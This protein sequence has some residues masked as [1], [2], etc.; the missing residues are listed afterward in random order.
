ME[1]HEG[2][3]RGTALLLEGLGDGVEVSNNI[4][5]NNENNDIRVA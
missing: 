4:N 3:K 2:V 1:L 5:R